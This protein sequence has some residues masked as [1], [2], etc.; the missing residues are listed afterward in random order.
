MENG[1]K[2]NA[3]TRT[4]KEYLKN[5]IKPEIKYA[6]TDNNYANTQIMTIITNIPSN[7]CGYQCGRKP[8]R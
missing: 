5:T 2:K 1:Y 7:C 8:N 6:N 4:T 3:I